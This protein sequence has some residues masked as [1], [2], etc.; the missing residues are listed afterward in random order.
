MIIYEIVA[1]KKPFK[2]LN[3]DEF[4]EKICNSE[5]P[6]FNETIPDAYKEL[7]ESCWN[8]DPKERPTFKEI[9]EKLKDF[10]FLENLK[11]YLDPDIDPDEFTEDFQSY[12]DY[13]DDYNATFNSENAIRIEKYLNSNP[14]SVFEEHYANYYYPLKS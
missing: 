6:K 12:V 4:I 9:V 13:I 2:N 1:Q 3:G 8:E 14:I 7:I 5:R 11:E 10:D